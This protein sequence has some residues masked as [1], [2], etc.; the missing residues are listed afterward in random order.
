MAHIGR[1][2]YQPQS[3]GYLLGDYC[4]IALQRVTLSDK[5][6]SNLYCGRCQVRKDKT[7]NHWLIL[8]QSVLMAQ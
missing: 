3:V 8:W 2:G 6:D 4:D 5:S 7:A 1:E